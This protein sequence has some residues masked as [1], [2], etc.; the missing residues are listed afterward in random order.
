MGTPGTRGRVRGEEARERLLV[1]GTRLVAEQGIVDHAQAIVAQ[2]NRPRHRVAHAGILKIGRLRHHQVAPDCL[3]IFNDRLA[4]FR[5]GAAALHRD[6]ER[7]SR[8]GVAIGGET[9]GQNLID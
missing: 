2:R 6:R 1:A 7:L 5:R 8:L 3:H 4:G 9:E